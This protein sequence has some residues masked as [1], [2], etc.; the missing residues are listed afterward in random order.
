MTSTEHILLHNGLPPEVTTV[1]LGEALRAEVTSPSRGRLTLSRR[2]KTGDDR[3]IVGE[4]QRNEYGEHDPAP[5]EESIYDGYDLVLELWV[6]GPT[7]P[8]LLHS[9]AARVFDKIVTDLAWPAVHTRSA[10]LVF[11]AWSPSRGRTDFPPNTS[12]DAPGRSLWEPYAKP[13]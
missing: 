2:V 6:S 13:S 9:E 8:D 1:R 11:S 12:N 10:G 3:L 7:N 5:G 4:V